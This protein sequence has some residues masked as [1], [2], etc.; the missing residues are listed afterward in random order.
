MKGQGLSLPKNEKYFISKKKK[1][2]IKNMLMIKILELCKLYKKDCNKNM[3]MMKILEL[4]KLYKKD[5][6]KKIC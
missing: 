5:C 3:L 6:N 1:I 4:C 2:V